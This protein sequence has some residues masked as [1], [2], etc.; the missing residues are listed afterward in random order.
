M[1]ALGVRNKHLLII[2]ETGISNYYCIEKSCI[3]NELFSDII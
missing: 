1:Y 2:L 3:M